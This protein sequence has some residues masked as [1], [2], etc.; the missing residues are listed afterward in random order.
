MSEPA[1]FDVSQAPPSL[2]EA[3]ARLQRLDPRYF[4]IG[5]LGTLLCW[6]LFGLDFD[7]GPLQAALTV[8]C[9]LLTQLA[10]T[11]MWRLPVFDPK[12]ALISSLSLCLLLRSNHL[13]LAILAAALAVLSKFILRA[14][15]K[16]ILNP[17]N[18]AIVILL[19]C[20][21]PIWV[22]PGQWGNATLFAFFIAC[23][24]MLVVFRSERVDVTIAFLVFWCAGLFGRSLWLGE[25][26]TIPV[27]RLE[28]GALLLFS[29]FMISDPK[30]TPDSRVGRILFA[31]LVATGA[32]WV[33]FKWFRTNGLLW[34]LTAFSLTVPLI[35]RL[36]PG[37]RFVWMRRAPAAEDLHGE[38][39]AAQ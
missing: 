17:T 4:Q 13:S 10:C 36:F 37:G 1:G 19:A 8:A 22:S 32:Y 9:A 25:P 3:W 30:T 35:D 7:I 24:G 27:H 2:G 5:A 26:M 23:I 29:F 21:A 33:Q 34:S 28:S 6:G 18:G 38:L 16:H 39:A 31:A 11:R 12:S 14:R 15:G 20:Q